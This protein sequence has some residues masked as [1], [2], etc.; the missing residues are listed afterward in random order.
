MDINGGGLWVSV[1]STVPVQAEQFPPCAI[2]L[3]PRLGVWLCLADD[4]TW[5]AP[6]LAALYGIK[7]L[8]TSIVA[9]YGPA[10]GPTVPVQRNIF[11]ITI[12]RK[13]RLGVALCR[14]GGG[15]RWRACLESSTC[16]DRW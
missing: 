5:P 10:S 13:Q 11:T 12:S 9:G 3:K 7:G 8:R 16:E 15:R 4:V 14:M 1:G 6:A 2:P